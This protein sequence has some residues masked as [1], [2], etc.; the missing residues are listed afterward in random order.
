MSSEALRG[1]ASPYRVSPSLD[2]VRDT[3]LGGASPSTDMSS[4]SN[5]MRDDHPQHHTSPAKVNEAN[6]IRGYRGIGDIVFDF[7]GTL[8]TDIGWVL[9]EVSDDQPDQGQGVIGTFNNCA[10]LRLIRSTRTKS[11]CRIRGLF[12]DGATGVDTWQL[13]DVVFIGMLLRDVI[14][15]IGFRA[16][17]ITRI[18]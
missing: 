10:T 13:D 1:N 7:D 9:F 6:A 16:G 12:H 18:A 5:V 4:L 8:S 14:G 11:P 17:T 3:S 15:F 2:F